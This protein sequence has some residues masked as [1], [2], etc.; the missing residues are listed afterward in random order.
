[1]KVIYRLRN[2]NAI[3][4]AKNVLYPEAKDFVPLSTDYSSFIDFTGIARWQPELLALTSMGDFQ[5]HSSKYS[6]FFYLY[7]HLQQKVLKGHDFLR[8]F[9]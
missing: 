7:G 4:A 8:Y 6:D 1:M 5:T 2:R 9:E 3:S